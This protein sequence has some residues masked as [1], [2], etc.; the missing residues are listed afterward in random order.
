MTNT[1]RR[2]SGISLGAIDIFIN[3]N[4]VDLGRYFSFACSIHGLCWQLRLLRFTTN[5]DKL[6]LVWDC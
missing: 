2:Y 3:N 1:Y 6:E 5:V 4:Q